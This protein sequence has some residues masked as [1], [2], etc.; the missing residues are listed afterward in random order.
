MGHQYHS[1]THYKGCALTVYAAWGGSWMT[2][3]KRDGTRVH[4]AHGAT[5]DTA[6]ANA[7]AWVDAQ[8]DARPEPPD[9]WLEATYE[10]RTELTDYQETADEYSTC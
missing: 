1:R 3:V 4:T 6:L 5:P 9:W 10:D 2:V 7:R 8:V